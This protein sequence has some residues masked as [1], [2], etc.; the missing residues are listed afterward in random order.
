MEVEGWKEFDRQGQDGMDKKW[1]EAMEILCTIYALPNMASDMNSTT[2]PKR[3][4][5]EKLNAAFN[6]AGQ[7]LVQPLRLSRL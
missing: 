2:A 3:V 4:P 5:S 7:E 1:D 6:G